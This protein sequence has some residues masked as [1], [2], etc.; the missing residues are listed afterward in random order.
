MNWSRIAIVWSLAIAVVAIAA[1]VSSHTKTRDTRRGFDNKRSR[2]VGDLLLAVGSAGLVLCSVAYFFEYYGQGNELPQPLALQDT[3]PTRLQPATFTTIP[4]SDLS[5][6][7]IATVA[8]IDYPA[9]RVTPDD[10]P[11]DV[12]SMLPTLT[13]T[14]TPAPIKPGIPVRMV[15]PSIEVDSAVKEIGTYWENGQL[16]WE[17]VPFVIGHYRTTAKAGEIGNAVFSGHVTSR[18]AG[19]IFKDLYKIQIGDDIR[20]F[21]EDAEFTYRVTGVK[22]VLPTEISVMDATPDA[23]ATL[24]T[25]AGE[26]DPVQRVFSHR[27]IVTAKLKK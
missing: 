10:T 17:T 12:A 4:E 26:W 22:I 16:L 24:I 7:K 27:L 5:A 15:I 19:N 25:C 14:A 13:L 6:I 21:T 11:T 3:E 20:V 1:L 23:S 2:I 18:S 8:T 9:V